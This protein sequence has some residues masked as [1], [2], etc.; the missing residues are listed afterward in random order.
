[1]SAIKEIL[2]YNYLYNRN[3]FFN[4]DLK[5]LNL[6]ND[7]VTLTYIQ[8][9]NIVYIENNDNGDYSIEYRIIYNAY[10]NRFKIILEDEKFVISKNAIYYYDNGIKTSLFKKKDLPQF[11][12]TKIFKE[13]DTYIIL[14]VL[15]NKK[16]IEV[17]YEKNNV[18]FVAFDGTVSFNFEN[19]I[20]DFQQDYYSNFVTSLEIVDNIQNYN[21]NL[22]LHEK[23][24]Y[25]NIILY[26]YIYNNIK[27]IFT[28]KDS[29]FT[30]NFNK[31]NYVLEIAI[32]NNKVNVIITK[33][34]N[35]KFTEFIFIK[36]KNIYHN[37]NDPYN[38]DLQF[39][40]VKDIIE[41][42]SSNIR[43]YYKNF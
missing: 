32:K 1:M 23:E 15:N 6:N 12:N 27:D 33:L 7:Q 39:H 35:N 42:I 38:E 40:N 24:R 16:I 31:L 20:F 28:I 4:N 30:F 36:N 41:T 5:S 9:A 34:K 11:K 43:Y 37:E 19:K 29:I 8:D 25:D 10:D 18:I 22:T 17:I 13:Y 2:D 26:H 14:D 3:K 21:Y